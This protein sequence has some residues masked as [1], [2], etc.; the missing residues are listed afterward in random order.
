MKNHRLL[1][2]IAFRRKTSR[3]RNL[4]KKGWRLSQQ[5]FLIQFQTL[6]RLSKKENLAKA[7]GIK[8]ETAN[9]L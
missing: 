3:M 2:E 7:S 8:E 4:E 1:F 9:F 6:G 5:S